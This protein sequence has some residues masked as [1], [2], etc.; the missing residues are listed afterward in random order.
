MAIRHGS[1]T[2]A[3]PVNQAVAR[4]LVVLLYAKGA[5]E[6]ITRVLNQHNIKVAHK[7]VRTVGSFFFKK[8]ER[9]TKERGHKGNCLEDQVQRLHCSVH[10]PDVTRFKDR[11]KEHPKARI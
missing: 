1:L 2:L 8:T 9:S 6:K 11:T 4:N 3:K 7:P 10:R 5:S